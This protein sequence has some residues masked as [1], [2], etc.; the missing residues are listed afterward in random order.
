MN[1]PGDMTAD[2]GDHDILELTLPAALCGRRMDHA[3]VT[4]LPEY[5][6]GTIQ[7][8]IKLG[9]ILVDGDRLKASDKVRGHET[10]TVAI[11][12]ARTEDWVAQDIDLEIVFEDAD[13]IVV[14]KPAGLVVHPGA[15]N[16]DGTLLNGLL[17]YYPELRGLPRAGIV[18]RLDKHTTGLM[19]VARSELARQSLIEQ[20]KTRSVHR[21]YLAVASGLLITGETIDQPIGRHRHDRLRMAVTANGKPAVTHIRV[22][23]KFRSHT[24]VEATLETGRTHQIRVHMAWRG[25]ALV[26]DPVYGGKPRPPRDSEQSLVALLQG[27]PRQALHARSLGLNHPE[28]GKQMRWQRDLPED[29]QSLVSALDL[30][31]RRTTQPPDR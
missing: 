8:W 7:G 17:A 14:N 9:Y 1:D 12:A 21:R 25:F 22:R 18:H 5:T 28:H 19:V 24:L 2:Q 26:G 6:R 20:L 4:L 27:F 11:P 29:M 10:V 31:C 30:D 15:G 3:L 13:L 23:E 16:P